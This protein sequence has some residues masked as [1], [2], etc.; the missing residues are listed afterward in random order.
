M[1]SASTNSI[2][3][4]SIQEYKE[5]A[6]KGCKN[7]GIHYLKIVFLNQFGWFCEDCKYS[8]MHDRLVEE[9]Q[10]NSSTTIEQV[11]TNEGILLRKIN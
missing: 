9:I 1:S 5:C 11:L 6:G 3:L 7:H 8:L 4:A 10:I 2:K